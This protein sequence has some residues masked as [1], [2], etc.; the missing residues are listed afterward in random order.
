MSRRRCNSLADAVYN[1]LFTGY[2]DVVT[3]TLWWSTAQNAEAEKGSHPKR[4]ATKVRPA[5]RGATLPA[6]QQRGFRIA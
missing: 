2:A 1:V 5:A 4:M 6:P 3:E